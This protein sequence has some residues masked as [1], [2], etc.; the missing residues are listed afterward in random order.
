MFEIVAL[1]DDVAGEVLFAISFTAV[2]FLEVVELI[3]ELQ[4]IVDGLGAEFVAQ[5]RE[6][7]DMVEVVLGHEA[8]RGGSTYELKIAEYRLNHFNMRQK[9]AD[10]SRAGGK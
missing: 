4:E 2:G 5:V 1:A 10:A 3:V 7:E 8:L 6:F 9:N